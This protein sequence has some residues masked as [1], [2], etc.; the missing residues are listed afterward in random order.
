MWGNN[1]GQ[2]LYR[3][4]EAEDDNKWEGQEPHQPGHHPMA[5]E[6]GE[7]GRP[8]DCS[9]DQLRVWDIR[10]VHTSKADLRQSWDKKAASQGQWKN[11]GLNSEIQG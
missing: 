6:W 4:Q 1:K 10:Q 7:P 8:R 11:P 2:L 5:Y 9:Q 3:G